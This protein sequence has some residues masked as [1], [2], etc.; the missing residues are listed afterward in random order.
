MTTLPT[1]EDAQTICKLVLNKSL[2]ACCQI[3]GPIESHYIWK[4]RVEVNNE[5]LCLMKTI[6]ARYKPIEKLIK[7]AHSYTLPEIIAV[8]IP[9]GYY[10]YLNWIEKSTKKCK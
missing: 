4:N 7:K 6:K 10:L 1:K 9:K 5:Y 8:D 3:I 2:A